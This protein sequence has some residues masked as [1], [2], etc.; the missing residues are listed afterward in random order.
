MVVKYV[1]L[2]NQAELYSHAM[3][4]ILPDNNPPNPD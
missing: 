2:I 1:R 3:N 4:Y